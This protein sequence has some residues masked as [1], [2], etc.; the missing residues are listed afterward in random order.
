M[1]AER[2]RFSCHHFSATSLREILVMTQPWPNQALHRTALL[3]PSLALEFWVFIYRGRRRS[4]SLGRSAATAG[5][6]LWDEFLPAEHAEGRRF[7][8]R[9][10]RVFCGSSSEGSG[11]AGRRCASG[12]NWPEIFLSMHNTTPNQSLQPTPGSRSSSASRLTSPGP[13]WL[14]SDR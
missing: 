13:A 4:V 3:R 9:V 11:I 6:W 10:F 2:F 7:F 8:F 14:S 12:V 1:W 5:L